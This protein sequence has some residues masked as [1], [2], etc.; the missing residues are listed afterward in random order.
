M[1]EVIDMDDD[2]EIFPRL[3]SRGP[4]EAFKNETILDLNGA[5]SSAEKPRPH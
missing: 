5:L 1:A 3:K 4:I 2:A